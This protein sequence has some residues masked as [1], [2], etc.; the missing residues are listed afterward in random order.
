[1][2]GLEKLWVVCL[3]KIEGLEDA[4]ISLTSEDTDVF[5]A[6]NQDTVAEH[7][8]TSWKDSRILTSLEGLLAAAEKESHVGVKRSHQGDEIGPNDEIE[9]THNGNVTL[10]LEPRYR[11]EAYS[12]AR[13]ADKQTPLEVE[14]LPIEMPRYLEYYF[15]YVHCWFPIVDRPQTLRAYYNSL[16]HGSTEQESRS[17]TALLWAI[18]ALASQQMEGDDK[19]AAPRL[20]GYQRTAT[21]FIPV[22]GEEIYLTH[23]QT[24]LLLSLLEIGQDKWSKAWFWAGQAVRHVLQICAGKQDVDEVTL[25]ALLATMIIDTIVATHLSLPPHLRRHDVKRFGYLKEDGYEEWN[26]WIPSGQTYGNAQPAFVLSNFNRLVDVILV[27]NDILTCGHLEGEAR[28]AFYSRVS[29]ELREVDCKISD[30]SDVAQFTPQHYVLRLY[31]LAASITVL[32]Q[33]FEGDAPALPLARLTCSLQEHLNDFVQQSYLGIAN[34][35]PIFEYPIRSACDAATASEPCF[36][37][38]YGLTEYADFVKGMTT[39]IAELSQKWSV[40]SKL[41]GYWDTRGA[42]VN[43]SP[44]RR[45]VL[46]TRNPMKESFPFLRQGTFE[47]SFPQANRASSYAMASD[48]EQRPLALNRLASDQGFTRSLQYSQPFS[49]NHTDARFL[50]ADSGPGSGSQNINAVSRSTILTDQ[51]DSA[52]HGVEPVSPETYAETTVQSSPSFQGDDVDAIFHNLVHLDA[53]DWA[54]AN[55]FQDLGFADDLAFQA[56]CED[57]DRISAADLSGPL[58]TGGVDFWPPDGVSGYGINQ[59][60]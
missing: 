26:S 22:N 16:K 52:M 47:T 21:S 58:A 17:T 46:E 49:A 9:E 50:M 53:N 7:L 39:V 48:T 24:M 55:P 2:R 12:Y 33:S 41:V 29:S 1:M 30:R 56:F 8:H 20:S 31:H 18:L 34:M 11:I 15:N 44:Q 54:A 28:R 38:N 32:R 19:T 35:S 10:P 23:V 57:N 42:P 14:A 27:L 37:V 43:D 13:I 51:F 5:Q 6:W 40:Y 60:R 4:V 59:F 3:G 45:S 25:T 36:G